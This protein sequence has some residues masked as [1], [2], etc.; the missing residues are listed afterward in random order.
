[1]TA[2][3]S[4]AEI[5]QVLKKVLTEKNY[6]VVEKIHAAEEL[7]YFDLFV[8]QYPAEY[9]TVTLTVRTKDGIHYIDKEFMKLFG[10]RA[11]ANIKLA[12]NVARRV[13]DEIDTYLF[14]EPSI[15][16]ILSNSRVSSTGALAGAVMNSY[17]ANYASVI[18]WPNSEPPVFLIPNGFEA[19]LSLCS[20]F[21]GIRSVIRGQQIG[22]LLKINQKARFDILR[23]DSPVKLNEKQEARIKQIID[24]FPLWVVDAEVSQVELKLAVM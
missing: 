5:E 19:Y 4:S 14:Y 3:S 20:N 10:S 9:P 18:T 22:V 1:M 21:Q 6:E 13:P 8:F 23:I 15:F 16:D 24:A 2:N 12:E 17:Q 11:A 7:F